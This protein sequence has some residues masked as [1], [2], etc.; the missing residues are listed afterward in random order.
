MKNRLVIVPVI[1]LM[2]LGVFVA[3]GSKL[4]SGDATAYGLVHAHY[5]G[6]VDIEVE[7]GVIKSIVFDEMELPYSWAVVIRTNEGTDEVPSYVYKIQGVEIAE[8][9]FANQGNAFFARMIKIGDE[10]LTLKGNTPTRGVYSNKNIDGAYGIETWVRLE[11]NA[12]WYWKQMAAGNYEVLR[13]DGSAY[14]IDWTRSNPVANTKGNR[15]QKSLNAYGANWVGL[16]AD[17][18]A[19]KGWTDNMNAMAEYLTGREPNNIGVQ[20]KGTIKA[21]N[22]K[23]TWEFDG[24][25]GATLV[26]ISEYFALATNA[27]NK[28]RPKIH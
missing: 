7:N 2:A 3:C 1:A 20:R 22:D 23:E 25:T 24:S 4:I 18:T 19:G 16:D 8:A 15:W 27:F 10:I 5:V 6:K 12:E 17:K 13:E 9:D 28:V 14:I 26:C 11:N 21:G